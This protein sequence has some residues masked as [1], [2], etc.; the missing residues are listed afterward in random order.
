MKA[1]INKVEVTSWYA[2]VDFYIIK[3][4]AL[5]RIFS[6]A[7]E[8][9]YISSVRTLSE[10]FDTL[11]PELFRYYTREFSKRDRVQYAY[12]WSG[13]YYSASE[14]DNKGLLQHLMPESFLRKHNLLVVR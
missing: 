6:S 10:F 1:Q 8:I 3:N 11:W 2:H 13:L 7:I 14:A 4:R 9:P 5:K 12:S